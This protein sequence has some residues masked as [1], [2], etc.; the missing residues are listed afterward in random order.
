MS[1]TLPRLPRIGILGGMGPMATADFLAKL[2]RATPVARDQDHFP[3]TVES[4][5]QIPDRVAALEGHGEDP[6][7]ALIAVGRRLLDAGCELIAMPCNT[8]HFWH[9][10][11]SAQL[12]VPFLHI[13]DA[14]AERLGGAR[15][16]GLMA[17]T[18]TL[19]SGLYPQRIGGTREWQFPVEAEMLQQVMPGVAAV[20]RDDLRGA[21]ELLRPV[22]RRLASCGIDTLVLG[23]TEIPLAL[24]QADVDVPVIDATMALAEATVAAATRLAHSAVQAAS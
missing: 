21:G 8:A 17:T 18:A 23:C 11:L 19:R 7:P 9:G 2:A 20:K 6:L 13:A 16:L 24:T 10:A 14:V 3:V 5:P 1:T 22:A 12:G 4:T 15:R